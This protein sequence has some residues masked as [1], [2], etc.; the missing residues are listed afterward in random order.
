MFRV[1][2]RIF[3]FRLSKFQQQQ[4]PMNVSNEKRNDCTFNQFK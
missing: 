4:Q 2:N 3:L 1:F